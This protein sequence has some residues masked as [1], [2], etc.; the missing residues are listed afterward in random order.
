MTGQKTL[1]DK[2]WDSHVVQ[3][4]E[5]GPD[6]LY[7]DRHYI[8]EVTSPQAFNGLKERGIHV[9]RPEKTL[10]TADHNIPTVNQD[11]PIREEFSRN[12]VDKLV[13]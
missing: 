4:I 5:Q 1:F 12:Q 7:I 11:K 6:V 13:E 10:A 2:I 8:H 3:S 9:F